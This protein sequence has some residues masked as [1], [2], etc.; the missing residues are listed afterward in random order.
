MPQKRL[1]SAF[2]WLRRRFSP[3]Q[4]IFTHL[5]RM[6]PLA[7]SARLWMPFLKENMLRLPIVPRSRLDARE[8][9]L[10]AATL[11]LDSKNQEIE[12]LRY[13]L[14]AAETEAQRLRESVP[15]DAPAKEPEIKFEKQP[16]YMSEEEEDV[17]WQ[18]D[19]DLITTEAAQALLKDLAFENSEVQ[20]AEDYTYENFHY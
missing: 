20:F 9:L 17:H 19:N 2:A 1:L 3:P 8:R 6:Y 5:Q 12:Q 13:L 4:M 18:L 15:Q 14:W 16:L 7:P 10:R 11:L